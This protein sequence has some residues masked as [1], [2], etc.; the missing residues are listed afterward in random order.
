MQTD[1]L[2]HT[3]VLHMIIVCPDIYPSQTKSLFQQ[4]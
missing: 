2:I 3:H 1:A 4:M